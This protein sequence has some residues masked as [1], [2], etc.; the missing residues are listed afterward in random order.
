[1]TTWRINRLWERVVREGRTLAD[2]HSA[3]TGSRYYP[4]AGLLSLRNLL[5]LLENLITVHKVAVP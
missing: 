1:M 4:A 5:P 2:A 3:G